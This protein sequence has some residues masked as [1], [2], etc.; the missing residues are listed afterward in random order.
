M[1][2]K[3]LQKIVDGTIETMPEAPDEEPE[4]EEDTSEIGYDPDPDKSA[5]EI[6]NQR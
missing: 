6:W 4:D 1:T 2:N 5:R 3:I